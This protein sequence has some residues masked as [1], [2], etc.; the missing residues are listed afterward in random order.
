MR[1]WWQQEGTDHRTLCGATAEEHAV[2]IT[3][4]VLVIVPAIL[5]VAIGVAP[6]LFTALG[7]GVV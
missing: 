7:G 3:L 1:L 2:L 5:A 4:M 6:V